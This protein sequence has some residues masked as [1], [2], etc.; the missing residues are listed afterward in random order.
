MRADRILEATVDRSGGA[1]RYDLQIIRSIAGITPFRLSDQKLVK[2]VDSAARHIER[3]TGLKL[4]PGTYI[5]EF[6]YPTLIRNDNYKFRPLLIPGLAA[7]ATRIMLGDTDISSTITTDL[8][9]DDGGNSLR[10]FPTT[11]GW[12]NGT[13]G[14]P[15]IIVE[16]SAGST[17]P[18]EMQELLGTTFRWHYDQRPED[19]KYLM[20]QFPLWQPRDES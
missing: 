7:S 17:L 12:L 6:R 9:R 5:A 1:S 4:F 19:Q 14:C 18:G 2:R 11:A 20:E 3:K 16:F 8:R 13:R 15:S 10:L